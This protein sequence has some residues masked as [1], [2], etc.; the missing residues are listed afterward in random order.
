MEFSRRGRR[1][2][3]QGG[4]YY[5]SRCGGYALYFS[6]RLCGLPLEDYGLKPRWLSFHK[7]RVIGRHKKKSTAAR[8]C[9]AVERKH[10]T[11]QK[12]RKA[13]KR[14]ETVKWPEPPVKSSD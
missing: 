13:V 3:Q 6:D 1:K 7:G 14:K 4:L 2:S 10:L 9:E 8:R 5:Y 12:R 11:K